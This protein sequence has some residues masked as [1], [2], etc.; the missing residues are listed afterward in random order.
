MADAARLADANA[1]LAANPNANHFM[2][3]MS[4]LISRTNFVA[5]T[6]NWQRLQW[7]YDQALK[8]A[9]AKAAAVKKASKAVG[10]SPGSRGSRSSGSGGSSTTDAIIAAI[11]AQRGAV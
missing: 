10:G 5:G 7:A 9:R 3:E 11:D 8:D 1:F 4:S 2:D 6:S